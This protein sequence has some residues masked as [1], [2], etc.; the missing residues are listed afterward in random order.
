MTQ[1]IYLGRRVGK[2]GT[3]VVFMTPEAFEKA[4]SLDNGFFER[5]NIE[6][7]AS[8]FKAPKSISHLMI[9]AIYNDPDAII[10]ET[11]RVTSV[12]IGALKMTN[13]FETV[14]QAHWYELDRAV[15]TARNRKTFETAMLKARGLDVA[16]KTL[17]HQYKACGPAQRLSFLIWLTQE[18]Q[19]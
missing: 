10:D 4:R 5:D 19:K 1:L 2:S 7:A 9:G 11:G 6:Q 17:Q 14:Y 16:V 8:Y 18:I 3:A 13:A 15:T 12:R